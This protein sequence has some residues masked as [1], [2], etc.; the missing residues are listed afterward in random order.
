M[1]LPSTAAARP[2]LP[3]KPGRLTSRR[4]SAFQPASGGNQDAFVAKLT[5]SG[6]LAYSSYLGGSGGTIGLPETGAAIAVDAQSNAYVAGTTGSYNFP[7]LNALQSTH[8]GSQADAFVVKV[9]A[10]G[11]GL[12]FSTYLG[13]SSVDVATAIAVDPAGQ[14]YVGGYTASVDFPA[15]AAGEAS[16]SGGYDAF[17]VGLPADG[18]QLLHSMCLGGSGN[19]V[20]NALAIIRGAVYL[21]GQTLSLTFPVRNGIQMNTAGI[22]DGFLTKLVLSAYNLPT[23]ATFVKWDSTT[24]GS[25]KGAYGANGY[26]IANDGTSYPAYAQV[27][28]TPASATWVPSTADVRALQKAAAS[29]RVASTWYSW[30]TFSI[31]L[32]LTDGL[33]HQVALYFLDWDSGIRAETIELLDAGTGAVLDSRSISGFGSGLYLVWNISGHALIRVTRTA[34]ANAVL[35]GIFFGGALPAQASAAFLRTDTSTHGSWRSVFG[36]NGYAIAN[37]GTSYPPYTPIG[38]NTASA[39]WAGSTAD[40]RALQK[41]AAPDRIASTW[42]SWTSFSVDVNLSDGQ[43][44]QVALYFLDWDSASRAQTVEVLDAGTGAV[45]ESRSISG[46]GSGLYLVWNISGHALIRVTRSGGA[47][48]VLSG[49]FFGGGIQLPTAA[50]VKSDP[51]TKGSW[52]GVYG[53][54]GYAIANDLTSYP[55]YAQVTWNQSTATWAASTADSRALQKAAASDRIASAWYTWANFSADINITDGQTHE[56]AMY[57]LDW[58]LGGARAEI[59]DVLDAATGAILDRR[60]ISVFTGGQYLVWNVSGH[61]VIRV[62]LTGG[63]NAVLSGMFFGT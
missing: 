20:V 18:R 16:N 42:Y 57:F 27:G 22:I 9:N 37:D 53:S 14:V 15:S 48:A 26:A 21:A 38:V 10:G 2:T 34:G 59:V 4:V 47:N 49:V 11:S 13:G 56:L 55:A 32:N 43:S 40:P 29:D 39:T 60:T 7:L 36:A 46:F 35:S 17:F 23:A 50:F 19:D 62:T 41:A 58:D 44:H 25:W 33:A 12:I 45:L 1:P 5:P 54:K 3:A 28:F 63:G 8:T 31:D 51:T 30:S 61:V 24:R 6:G 52:K